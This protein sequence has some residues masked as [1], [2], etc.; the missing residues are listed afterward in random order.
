LE[1]GLGARL[2]AVNIVDADIAV[3]SQIDID[4]ESWL[5]NDREKIAFEKAGILR[6]GQLAV[7]AD[8]NPP[9]SLCQRLDDLACDVRWPQQVAG[10]NHHHG[11]DTLSDSELL[12]WHGVDSQGC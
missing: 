6:A 3:I 10:A 4:H 9:Q 2:D 8:A 7:I 11:F 5:G 1:V 12:S